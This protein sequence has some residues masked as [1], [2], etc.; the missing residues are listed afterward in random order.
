MPP[1]INAGKCV[2][3]GTCASIC[4]MNV[5]GPVRRG[6]VPEVRY[7]KECWHC[8][9]CVMDCPVQAIELRYPLPYQILFQPAPGLEE[10]EP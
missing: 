5:F 3:C 4:C 1:K 6:E 7:P 2:A 10:V 9:A 8:R